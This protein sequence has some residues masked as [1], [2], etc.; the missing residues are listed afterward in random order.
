M[1]RDGRRVVRERAPAAIAPRLSGIVLAES[2]VMDRSHPIGDLGAERATLR[3]ERR[4][5]ERLRHN[6]LSTV[7]H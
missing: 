1:G 4:A 2:V 5:V 3:E 6:L 7:S